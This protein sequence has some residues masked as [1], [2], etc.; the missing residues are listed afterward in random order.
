MCCV[1]LTHCQA[2][3]HV[4]FGPAGSNIS[5]KFR[6]VGL[7]ISAFFGPELSFDPAGPIIS[8]VFGLAGPSISD[9]FGPG[10]PF[11]LNS[12]AN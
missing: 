8:T 4:I 9:K 5:D 2:T 12:F 1:R 7:N 3:C 11:G 6:P 10:F